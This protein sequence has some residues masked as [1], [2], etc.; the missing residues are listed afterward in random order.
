[1]SR[2]IHQ[3]EMYLCIYQPYVCMYVCIDI[4]PLYMFGGLITAAF[5]STAITTSLSSSTAVTTVV[6]T[7]PTLSST[8]DSDSG[9][10]NAGA[11]VGGVIGGIVAVGTVV[12]ICIVVSYWLFIYKK[13]KGIQCNIIYVIGPVKIDH[14]SAKIADFFVF[15]LS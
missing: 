8:G 5:S 1:M 9:G 6:V 14:L 15:A 7:S 3:K 4:L 2:V 12:I 13:R 11:I 10:S